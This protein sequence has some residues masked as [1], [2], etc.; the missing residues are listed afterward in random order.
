MYMKVSLK[1]LISNRNSIFP[2][3]TEL[4]SNCYDKNDNTYYGSCGNFV[5]INI[6][7]D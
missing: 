6:N 7:S 3:M 2:V 5:Y 1:K 4:G